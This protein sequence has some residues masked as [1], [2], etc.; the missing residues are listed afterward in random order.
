LTSLG[1]EA[2]DAAEAEDVA[3]EEEMEKDNEVEPPMPDGTL[4]WLNS[5][6]VSSKSTTAAVAAAAAAAVEKS[7]SSVGRRAD[8]EELS[9]AAAAIVGKALA[10]P[11]FWR[12]APAEE[13]E[14]ELRRNRAPLLQHMK[15]LAKDAKRADQRRGRLRPTMRRAGG[16]G[17]RL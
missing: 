5:I 16:T 2:N 13:L 6:G 8:A 7:G 1:A 17:G 4:D 11:P 10:I 14:R 15:R 9:P 3:E 12:T